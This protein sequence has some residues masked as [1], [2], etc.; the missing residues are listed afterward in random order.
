MADALPVRAR[1][2][3]LRAVL[4]PAAVVLLMKQ[5]LQCCGSPARVMVLNGPSLKR[6]RRSSRVLTRGLPKSCRSW[7]RE[8]YLGTAGHLDAVGPVLSYW[9]KRQIQASVSLA[10]QAAG[11]GGNRKWVQSERLI[12]AAGSIAAFAGAGLI[13]QVGDGSAAGAFGCIG[14]GIQCLV[15]FRPEKPSPSSVMRPLKAAIRCSP[16]QQGCC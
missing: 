8:G 12:Q 16:W 13:K 10:G 14:G 5:P 9:V 4:V 6:K 3:V 2:K 1:V 7:K 15:H 11:A